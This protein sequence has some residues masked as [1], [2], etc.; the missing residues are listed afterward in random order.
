LHTQSDFKVVK[1]P[2]GTGEM[3]QQSSVLLWQKAGI[4][5]PAPFQEVTTPV[6]TPVTPVSGLH[7][8]LYLCGVPMDMQANTHTHKI[9]N[10]KETYKTVTKL[11]CDIEP[12]IPTH[13][14]TEGCNP[15]PRV[16][17]C[18]SEASITRSAVGHSSM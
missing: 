18:C 8:N 1:R 6:V 2:T 7:G 13:K 16:S 3:T 11:S 12:G 17:I 15:P 14:K 9:R 5:Y 10:K 4:L